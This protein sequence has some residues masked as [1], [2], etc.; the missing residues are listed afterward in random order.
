MS[1][2][3]QRTE[4]VDTLAAWLTA[5][6]AAPASATKGSF[7][8]P[9]LLAVAG[10]PR[11]GRNASAMGRALRHSGLVVSKRKLGDIRQW[12]WFRPHL[13]AKHPAPAKAKRRLVMHPG[14]PAG[15]ATA[16][17]IGCH[18]IEGW[19]FELGGLLRLATSPASVKA[20]RSMADA[21]R[22]PFPPVPAPT[23]DDLETRARETVQ[24]TVAAAGNRHWA[25][26]REQ[27]LDILGRLDRAI[28]VHQNQ[29]RYALDI[30]ED[31][32]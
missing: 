18:T 16:V 5:Y 9:E 29:A 15:D 6:L 26:Y 23:L 17:A 11:N 30:Q 31:T 7:T 14:A 10:L 22:A 27:S 12:A 1:A 21:Y 24:R 8:V 3:A 20:F 25:F 19:R 28:S 4:G 13:V 32:P 2:I